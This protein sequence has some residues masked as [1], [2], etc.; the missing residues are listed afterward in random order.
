MVELREITYENMNECFKLKVSKEQ[1]NFVA[2]NVYTLA[3]C[4]VEE[5]ED[6]T[7]FTPYAIYADDIMVGFVVYCFYEKSSLFEDNCY[8]FWRIMFDTKYQGKGYGK[9]TVAKVIE[10]IKTFPNGKA[11]A[12]Y[13][14]Y[15]PENTVS[16]NLFH[17]FGFIDTDKKFADDDNEIIARLSI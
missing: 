2:S 6:G 16:K 3:E 13:M 14:S 8:H 10:E 17:S 15:E 7:P 9:Q 5:R 11:E 12:I 1:E 4:F